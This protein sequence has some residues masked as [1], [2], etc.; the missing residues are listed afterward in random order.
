MNKHSFNKGW[1][2]L[3]VKDT[4]AFTEELKRMLGIKS[5][6]AFF[7]RRRGEVK[8]LYAEV[9]IIE[10]VFRKYGVPKTKVWGYD[11]EDKTYEKRS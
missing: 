5:Q 2:M 9:I 8:H 11:Y 4:A 7:A 6:N 3:S 1:G 10:G